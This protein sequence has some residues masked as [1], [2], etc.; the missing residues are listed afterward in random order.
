MYL[1]VIL[2]KDT[3]KQLEFQAIKGVKFKAKFDT[4]EMTSDFGT[5]LLREIENNTGIISNL[6]LNSAKP[7]LQTLK[8]NLNTLIVN[9]LH[10][11]TIYMRGHY[12]NE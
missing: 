5:V 10:L 4:P 3:M 12:F 8:N 7:S 11:L 1:P 2:I 6:Y 9:M